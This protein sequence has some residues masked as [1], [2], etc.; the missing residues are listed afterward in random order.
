[1]ARW[2]WVMLFI[3]FGGLTVA[4]VAAP[5]AAPADSSGLIRRGDY[6]THHVAM[7]VQCHSPRDPE[8][9]IVESQEFRGAPIPVQSFPWATSW[10]YASVNLRGMPGWSTEEAIHFLE[11]G[12]RFDGKKPQLP[13]PPFRLSH[14]DA[15]AVVAYLKSLK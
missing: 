4:A 2:R 6:L 11:T 10:A 9:N 5:K 3:S 8:G 15:E 12:E 1:M 7:C 14:E 13:M